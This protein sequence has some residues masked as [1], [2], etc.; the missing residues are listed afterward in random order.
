MTRENIICSPRDP[1]PSHPPD[2]PEQPAT[3][4]TSPKVVT[5]LIPVMTHRYNGSQVLFRR[6]VACSAAARDQAERAA[7]EIA[8]GGNGMEPQQRARDAAI[9]TVVLA[10]AAA[11]SY[12][13][14][15]YVETGA[16]PRASHGSPGG[17]A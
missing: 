3:P 6:A 14:W 5:E 1:Y 16:K 8:G 11:E 17:V 4:A 12:I 9:E 2:H 10:Q 15:I 13:N 7:Q